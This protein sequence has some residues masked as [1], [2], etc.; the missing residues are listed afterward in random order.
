M[1]V[2]VLLISLVVPITVVQAETPQ[3]DYKAY[4]GK[5]TELEMDYGIYSSED[6]SEGGLVYAK[7]ID[8]NNDGVEELYYITISDSIEEVIMSGN[9]IIYR[10][11]F[12]THGRNADL[13]ID[14]VEGKHGNYI[15]HTSAYG[16][17]MGEEPY[18]NRYL[19]DTYIYKVSSDLLMEEMHYF[20]EEASSIESSEIGFEVFMLDDVEIS[21]EEYSK[22]DSYYDE[23]NSTSIMNGSVGANEIIVDS[24]SIVK[25]LLKDLKE[26]AKPKQFGEDLYLKMDEKEQDEIRKYFYNFITLE[27]YD[28]SSYTDEQILDYIGFNIYF[29][30]VD[31][32]HGFLNNYDETYKEEAYKSG[33]EW[34]GWYY[35]EVS[36]DDVD[37]YIAQLFGRKVE[38]KETY[39]EDGEGPL[40]YYENGSYYFP[41]HEY[42]IVD[43]PANQIDGVYRLAEDLLYVEYTNYSIQIA[44][45]E[46]YTF[47]DD[48]AYKDYQLLDYLTDGDR[49]FLAADGSGYAILKETTLNGEKQWTLIEK[50]QSGELYDENIVEK[51]Q[52]EKIASSNIQF[53]Y[54]TIATYSSAAEFTS[55]LETALT[56]M[57]EE[58][59]DQGKVEVA[60]Y[61]EYV[62]QT[63]AQSSIRV[64][65][66]RVT[67]S[68]E[69]SSAV[70]TAASEILEDFQALIK[71]KDIELTKEIQTVHRFNTNNLDVK[72]PITIT[73]NKSILADKELNDHI[74]ISLDGKQYS[75]SITYADLAKLLE[76][77]QQI[78]IQLK[79]DDAATYTILYMDDENTAMSEI[80]QSFKFTVPAENEFSTILASTGIWGGHYSKTSKTIEFSTKLAGDYE[81]VTNKIELADIGDLSPELQEAVTFMVSKGY[82][83]VE[84]DLFNPSGSIDRNS[85]AKSLVKILF[86]LDPSLKTSFSDVEQESSY[87]TYIASGE[88]SDIIQGYEDGTFRGDV[89]VS[90]QQ[91]LSFSGRALADKKGY[92]YPENL[93]EYLEFE[94]AIHISDSAKEDIALAVREGLIDSGGLLLPQAEITREAAASI[95]YKL[96]MLLYEAPPLTI[97]SEVA[98]FNEVKSVSVNSNANSIGIF[99]GIGLLI[100][101]LIAFLIYKVRRKSGKTT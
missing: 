66:N 81:V 45:L 26:R 1:I 37:R 95:L 33:D 71:K 89:S 30:F 73:F 76:E 22:L 55:A 59:N 19:I 65:K 99:V 92:A 75:V 61:I 74:L 28:V 78:S 87:Y 20:S 69:E 53:D 4:F 88:N 96:F 90:M 68:A 77:R 44:D 6:E 10:E 39:G 97:E 14:L 31:N 47:M 91:V 3:T 11:S 101:G 41:S 82:F 34:N 29:G 72:K 48:P 15:I 2:L 13:S 42:G 84:G 38:E 16:T 43:S 79:K 23:E 25:D 24:E 52:S 94:D 64:E 93:E 83:D 60:N 35:I 62:I 58:L 85:Y 8:L 18:S 98:S 86:S 67:V 51:Y 70:S 5:L 63:L 50:N 56:N 32:S 49:A 21:K 54:P 9:E 57:A 7:L 12:E 100:V 80:Q 46:D 40:I 36:K 17:G 27:D